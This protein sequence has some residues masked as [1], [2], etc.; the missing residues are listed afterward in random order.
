MFTIEIA[1]FYA[2]PLISQFMVTVGGLNINPHMQVLDK[3][4]N[5]IPGLYAVG[6]IAG[7]FFAVEY[8]LIC[9]GLSHGRALTLGYVLGEMLAKEDIEEL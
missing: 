5:V 9:P 8:P 4:D 3:E 7:N 6:N 1:P 2:I